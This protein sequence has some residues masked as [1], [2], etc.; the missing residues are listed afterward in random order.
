LVE[1]HELTGFINPALDVVLAFERP[2]FVVISPRT[3]I[4]PS[5]QSGVVRNLPSDRRLLE[6][7]SVDVEFV[8]ES[9]GD[10]VVTT[11]GGPVGLEVT[12]TRVV[13]MAMPSGRPAIAALICLM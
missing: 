7:E 10:E 3:I 11:F 9:L 1:R 8:E 12:P 4:L 5:A 13:V 6:E 2:V